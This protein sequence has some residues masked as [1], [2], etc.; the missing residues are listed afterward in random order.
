ML[1]TIAVLIGGFSREKE[2]SL[3][4]GKAIKNALNNLLYEVVEI[5]VDNDIVEKLKK[6]NPDLAFIALHGPYGE[7]GCIQGLLEIL[8]VRYTHSGVMASA[9][10]MN[11]AMSKHIFCSLYIDNPK[12][13][14][15][16]QED[17]LKNNI[18][19]K[20]PYVLK[21]INEGSSIGVHIVFSHEDYLKLNNTLCTISELDEKKEKYIPV[22]SS[23]WITKN[24]SKKLMIIEEYIPGVELQTAVLLNEAIG[25]IEIRPKNKFFDYEAKYTGGLAEYVF[26]A[27]IPDNIYKTTLEYALKVHQ[28][29]GCKSISRS[30][31]RYNPKNNT[32]KMLEINTHPG[33]TELSLVPKIAKLTKG[34]NFDELVKI[35]VEDSLQHRGIRD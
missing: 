8:G 16:S 7:D 26:P 20:Y 11:K 25:T 31:F 23:T 24:Y 1:P 9:I 15:L 21:P 4:S 27:E 17:V 32:L 5:Y 12:G 22:S 6:N 35:I 14:V 13:Y 28:F 10:A 19:I 34:I 2:V 30:D 18:K 3:M 33:F 29:L